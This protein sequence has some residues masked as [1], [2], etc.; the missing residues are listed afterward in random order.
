[1]SLPP[2][3]RSIEEA[4]RKFLD[5]GVG[6]DGKGSVIIRS[7]ELGAYVCDREHGGVWIDAYHQNS[8]MAV[9]VTGRHT[10]TSEG[11]IYPVLSAYM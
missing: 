5:L 8:G 9:D 2:A 11:N 4:A 1:M 6:E 7:G 10:Y 3:R